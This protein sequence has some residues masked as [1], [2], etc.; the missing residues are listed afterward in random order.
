MT[1]IICI[2]CPK[3]CHLAVDESPLDVKGAGC[4][5]GVTYGKNEVTHPVRVVRSTVCIQNAPLGRVSVTTD[6][7]VPKNQVFAVM[8]A[9]NDVVLWAPVQVG[10]VV[11]KDVCGTGV[12][13]VVTRDLPLAK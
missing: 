4:E 9:L 8:Q 12:N 7:A 1:E 6:G 11:L 5:R 3:G 2:C 10:D 13:V